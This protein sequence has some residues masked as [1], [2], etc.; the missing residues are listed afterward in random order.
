VLSYHLFDLLPVEPS[1]LVWFCNRFLLLLVVWVALLLSLLLIFFFFFLLL[2]LLVV[3]WLPS[4]VLL[5]FCLSMDDAHWPQ[6][7]RA[8]KYLSRLSSD[9]VGS[10]RALSVRLQM[11]LTPSQCLNYFDTLYTVRRPTFEGWL[12]GQPPSS[13][14]ARFSC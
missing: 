7:A 4:F 6:A 8:L 3:V 9:G 13:Q 12:V 2:L 5:L 10:R 11:H 14:T 1:C